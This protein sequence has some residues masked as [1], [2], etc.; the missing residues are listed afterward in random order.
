MTHI[1]WKA[2]TPP[3]TNGWYIGEIISADNITSHYGETAFCVTWNIGGRT[4]VD[5]F[6]LFDQSD[7]KRAYAQDKLENLCKAAQIYG[8]PH[9][10]PGEVI[11]F[12]TSP[13]I[14]KKV[15]IFINLF[16]PPGGDKAVTTIQKYTALSD[17]D[18]KETEVPFDDNIPF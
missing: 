3:L 6:K 4:V 12:D 18:S 2:T 1:S 7:T 14:G 15:K 13:L 16:T 17:T 9:K 8:P 5:R 11:E 10:N